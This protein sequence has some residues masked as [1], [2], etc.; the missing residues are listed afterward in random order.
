MKTKTNKSE[1]T[2][3]EVLPP[4][5]PP[6]YIVTYKQ[7]LHGVPHEETEIVDGK[8]CDWLIK[9]KESVI[10]SVLFAIKL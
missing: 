4:V 3:A 6:R 10:V 5:H 1:I 8:L 2:K 9:K 7:N